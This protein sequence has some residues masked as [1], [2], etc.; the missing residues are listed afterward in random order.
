MADIHSKTGF[1]TDA[2]IGALEKNDEMKKEVKVKKGK[3]KTPVSDDEKK[4]FTTDAFSEGL[5]IN[6]EMN[7]KQCL[8]NACK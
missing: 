2:F 8:Q 3:K 5:K 6:E 7:K 1:I 4:G